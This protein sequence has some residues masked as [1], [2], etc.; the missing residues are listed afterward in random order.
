MQF[1]DNTKVSEHKRCERRYYFRHHEHLRQ[2][3]YALPLV[4]GLAWHSAMDVVW[5]NL[6]RTPPM[7]DVATIKEAFCA[8]EAVWEEQGL[9]PAT[10]M[11]PEDEADMKP[12]TPVTALCMIEEY[13]PMRRRLIQSHSVLAIEKPFAVPLE[14]DNEELWYCGRLD[15]VIEGP[16][17]VYVV[18]HKTTA[19]YKKDGGF[20]ASFLDSFSPDSQLDGY[21]YAAH[22]TYGDRFKGV[23]IDGALV[24]QHVHDKYCWLPVSRHIDQLDSW[25]WETVQEVGRIESNVKTLNGMSARNPPPF[26]PCFRKQTGSCWDFNTPCPYLD[27]CKGLA[28]PHAELNQ[29]GVPLGY[30]VDPW[31]PFEINKIAQLGAFQGSLDGG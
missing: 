22:L 11:S 12:R 3:G 5:E 1:Y 27:L 6:S 9:K 4:F 29:I 24:H 19:L 30:I 23:L 21:A 15:K 26:M 2:E 31:E 14:P 25:L 20:R 17:G 18:D 13:I 10:E 28:N 16:D 8:F 7:D